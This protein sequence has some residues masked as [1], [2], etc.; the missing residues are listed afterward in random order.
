MLRLCCW[1]NTYQTTLCNNAED[2][3][4][5]VYYNF[6]FHKFSIILS[7]VMHKFPE[8]LGTISKF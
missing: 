7:P 1:V 3:K 4:Y 8:D 2:S 5:Q 6:A